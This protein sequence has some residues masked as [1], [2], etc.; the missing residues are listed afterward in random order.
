MEELVNNKYKL[1]KGMKIRNDFLCPITFELLRDPVVAGDGFSYERCAIEKW[2]RSNNTSPLTGNVM[3]KIL[4]KNITLKNIIQDMISEDIGSGL[5]T[6][7]SVDSGK[8]LAIFTEKAYS[9]KCVGPPDSEWY[10]RYFNVGRQGCVG[11]RQTAYADES[12]SRKEVVLFTDLIVSR[13]HFEISYLRSESKYGIRDLGS[14]GG[15]FVRL[16]PGEKKLLFPGTIILIGTHQFVVSSIDNNKS[17]LDSNTRSGSAVDQD[18]LS[19]AESMITE[20]IEG[21]SKGSDSKAEFSSTDKLKQLERRLKQH[22]EVGKARDTPDG[23]RRSRALSLTC[24]GPDGSPYQGRVAAVGPAGLTIGRLKPPSPRAGGE[25]SPSPVPDD[26]FDGACMT[27]AK[28]SAVSTEHAR[29]SMDPASGDFFICDGN[30]TRASTNGT[31]H[32]LS[33]VNQ[34]SAYHHIYPGLELLFGKVRFVVSEY[35]DVKEQVLSDASN[36]LGGAAYRRE[37]ASGGEVGLA[38]VIECGESRK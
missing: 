38:T 29:V 30:G 20:F 14:A 25:P 21:S 34:V 13:K 19:D 36:L 23:A 24:C 31:W 28:D 33:G 32:R 35:T 9:L 4:I 37:A 1:L 11:G 10:E 15:T 27:L 16:M 12:L 6:K 3:D 26:L 17:A 8:I 7:D 2:L 5:Y 22:N 18:I